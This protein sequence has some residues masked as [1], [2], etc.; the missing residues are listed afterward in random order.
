MRRRLYHGNKLKNKQ[1]DNVRPLISWLK[2][3]SFQRMATII[4]NYATLSEGIKAA[5]EGQCT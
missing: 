1:N 3:K 5:A 2:Q 4:V